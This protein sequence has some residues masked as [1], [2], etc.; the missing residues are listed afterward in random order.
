M[1]NAGSFFLVGLPG[2]GKSTLG[3]A[4]ARHLAYEFIDADQFLVSRT[5]VDIPT[6]FAL[7]GESGFRQREMA[8]IDELTQKQGIVL[9]TGGGAVLNADNRVALQKRGHVV[10]LYATPDELY[11]RLRYDKGRPL[12]QVDNPLAKLNDLYAQRDPLYRE[13]ADD[14]VD[15][16]DKNCMQAVDILLKQLQKQ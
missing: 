16:S 8:V 15:I 13:I 6:I 4:L 9:A 10:Y 2:A 14:I 12:L 3:R 1:K 5:G 7:E 11:Q